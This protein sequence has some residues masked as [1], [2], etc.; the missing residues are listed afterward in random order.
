MRHLSAVLIYML[1]NAAAIAQAAV[2][3]KIAATTLAGE[4][5]QSE[6]RAGVRPAATI[7][8]DADLVCAGKPFGKVVYTIVPTNE[9]SSRD[10]AAALSKAFAASKSHAEIGSRLDCE[11]ERRLSNTANPILA[12]ACR[13]KSDGGPTL[14]MARLRGSLLQVV[15]APATAYPVL[16]ALMDAPREGISQSQLTVEAKALWSRPVTMA[17]A[18]DLETIKTSLMNARVASSQLQHAAAESGFRSALELQ[19]RLSGENDVATNEILLD[20]ALSVS[21]QGREDEAEALLRRAAP[22]AE[23]SVRASD[24][25]R[26]TAYQGFLAAN[27]GDFA[28]ALGF[29][30]AATEAWRSIATRNSS[31]D[32]LLGGGTEATAEAELAH[33]LNFE[34]AMMLRNDQITGAFASAGE[35][36][37][38]VDRVSGEPR[39]WKSDILLTLGEVSSAQGRLS[40]AEAYLK[41]ALAERQQIFGEGPGTLKVRTTLARAYQVEGMFTSAIITYREAIRAARRLPRDSIAFTADDLTPF[42]A[43]IVEYAATINDPAARLGL[44]A[45]AFD[46]FQLVRVPLIDRTITM[47]SARLSADTPDLAKLVHRLDD[48]SQEEASARIR[49]ADQQSLRMEERSAETEE[50]LTKN[51]ADFDRARTTVQAEIARRFP[52]FTQL[53]ETSLP[54]LDAV[55]GRLREHEGLVTF[56]IGR[57]RSFVQMVR[58]EGVIIAPVPAGAAELQSAVARLRRGLEIQ[59]RSVSE[60]DLDT[61]HQLYRDLFGGIQNELGQVDRLVIVPSGSLASLPFGLLVTKPAGAGDYG[62]AHWLVRELPLAYAPSTGSFVTLRSSR[63][64]GNQPRLLLA[65]GNPVLGP[66]QSALAQRSAM[67]SFSGACLGGGV[68]PPQLLQSLAS[69]PDTATEIDS[70]ARS[71]RSTNVDVRLG[72]DANEAALRHENL[73]DYRIIYFATHGLLPGELR[74]QSAPGLVLTPP[75]QP[76]LSPNDDGLLDSSEIAKLSI[77][78]D[79]VV[80]S[81]CNTAANGKNFGGESLSGLAA[82]FFH[83]GARSLV[84]SHWQVPSAATTRLM[85]SMFGAMGAAPDLTIDDALR[86]AQLDMLGDARTAHPF[87]WAAFVIMGDGA[88]KPLEVRN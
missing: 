75:L 78:A 7:P 88:I 86:K 19:T 65:Y 48:V 73:E 64:T 63:L 60:F 71:L 45:E 16:R 72:R 57:D 62:K 58:R 17:S 83:A 38:I 41:G 44:F 81:A 59:G 68:T 28:A 39:W 8:A 76:A 42:A 53:A 36:L 46:A 21:N 80:L 20:L 22:I 49:L 23:Q 82:S 13:Q 4:T 77:K 69:L 26:L 14:V 6:T 1:I 70:V 33:A 11:A 40:A 35:A 85:S 52:G 25:A 10:E 3:V 18:T 37:L 67:A 79:L 30:K 47:A 54:T 31:A 29:A 55:R 74:C 87:F 66:P 5:C 2:P 84:V 12:L 43:S 15:E 50:A 51:I 9:A 32:S 27:R 24:R 34:A 61:A 56:L